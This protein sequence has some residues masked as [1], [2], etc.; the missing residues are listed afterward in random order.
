MA[1]PGPS[2][3]QIKESNFQRYQRVLDFAGSFARARRREFE[4]LWREPGKHGLKAAELV[5][6][7]ESLITLVERGQQFLEL[8]KGQAP[9]QAI[10]T[11][12]SFNLE[13]VNTAAKQLE[14][15][16]R[17]LKQDPRLQAA[18]TGALSAPPPARTRELAD[19][20]T[21]ELNLA[22]ETRKLMGMVKGWLQP[23]PPVVPASKG[24]APRSAN[25]ARP[26]VA[27]VRAARLAAQPASPPQA[28]VPA[29]PVE[30]PQRQTFESAVA[31]VAGVLEK[32]GPKLKIVGISLEATGLPKKQRPWEE[33][34]R[35]LPEVG[36]RAGLAAA[37]VGWAL[38][39]A[40]LFY[41]EARAVQAAHIALT[42][43]RQAR[44]MLVEAR[45]L[46]ARMEVAPPPVR[47]AFLGEFHVGKF[48]ATAFPLS[49]LHLSFRGMSPLQEMFPPPSQ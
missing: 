46:Q 44:L 38:M 35:E 25:T 4:L 11:L 36:P 8:A 30:D 22:S 3:D 39:L 19:N 47:R 2:S 1:P 16:A 14:Q 5:K 48:K 32:V 6:R 42:Q 34:E 31:L 7:T 40:E 12:S 20:A 37:Q 15:L 28:P 26:T 49:H 13:Q 43:W 45:E 27:E 23:E 29:A 21:G 17:E 33:V 18:V 41:R 10:A 9:V 24:P